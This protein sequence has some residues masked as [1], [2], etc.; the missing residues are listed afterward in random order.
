MGNSHSII[1]GTCKPLSRLVLFLAR[2]IFTVRFTV[3]FI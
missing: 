3:N 1:N 2:T